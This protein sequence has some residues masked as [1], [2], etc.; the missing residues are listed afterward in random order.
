M[1]IRDLNYLKNIE[2]LKSD[3]NNN[4]SQEK[5]SEDEN[6]SIFF[7]S[8]TSD[9]ESGIN[10]D[11]VINP[12][13]VE[14][15]NNFSNTITI[16]ERVTSDIVSQSAI[17]RDYKDTGI[18]THTAIPDKYMNSTAIHSGEDNQ[19]IIYE[20]NG[21][22][23]SMKI[24]WIKD[25][26]KNN[27]GNYHLNNQDKELLTKMS[28]Y[29]SLDELAEYTG[30]EITETEPG[31]RDICIDG[32]H[33]SEY[34]DAPGSTDKKIV[35]SDETPETRS[36]QPAWNFSYPVPENIITHTVIVPNPD[37]DTNTD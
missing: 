11:M 4:V 17:N 18:Y 24:G 2:Q 30:I 3:Q 25:Y 10:I 21:E 9:Y 1:N 32:L 16:T 36:S 19:F 12:D 7:D 35:V 23:W 29:W 8:N 31:V 37:I 20:L 26:L 13:I 22:P 15:K 33:F 5:S 6:L 14:N 34:S 28:N 27:Q